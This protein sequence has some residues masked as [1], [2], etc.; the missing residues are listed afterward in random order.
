MF[1]VNLCFY[2]YLS[3]IIFVPYLGIM[4]IFLFMCY[5]MVNHK[6]FFCLVFIAAVTVG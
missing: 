1:I 4:D 5:V 6:D 2:L 3:F